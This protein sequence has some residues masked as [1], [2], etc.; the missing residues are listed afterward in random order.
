M[1]TSKSTVEILQ[2][3]SQLLIE[4][5]SHTEYGKRSARENQQNPFFEPEQEA[6]TE[7][8]DLKRK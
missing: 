4:D 7:M 1:I 8:K 2:Y 6:N 3:L 5:N